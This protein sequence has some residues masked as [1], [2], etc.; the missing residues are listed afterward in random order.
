M[1][2]VINYAAM[3]IQQGADA[4]I[5]RVVSD[6]NCSLQLMICALPDTTERM[7]VDMSTG[8]PRP[9]AQ[10]MLTRNI[11]DSNQQQAHAGAKAMRRLIC[12]WFVWP[13]YIINGLVPAY[14]ASAPN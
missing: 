3:A 9:L 14:H 11:C 10:A 5:K 13:N 8:R 6:P 2:I 12:D 1:T 7:L 4:G